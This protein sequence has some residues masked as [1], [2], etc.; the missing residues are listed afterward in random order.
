MFCGAGSNLYLLTNWVRDEQALSIEQGVH[1]MTARNANF[2]SLHDRGTIEVGR[3]GD[4]NVFAL[5]EIETRGLVRRHDLPD[6]SWRFS[7]PS[8]GF[9]ATIVAGVPTML[10]GEPTGNLPAAM[11]NALT[12]SLA[13]P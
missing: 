6:G 11:G 3:R 5:D 1:C 13:T 10:D 8:A 12:A 2:F 9:R 7:R 4:L